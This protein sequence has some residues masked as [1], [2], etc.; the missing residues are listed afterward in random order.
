MPFADDLFNKRVVGNCRWINRFARMK[1][2]P[3]TEV[4]LLNS[5]NGELEVFRTKRLLVKFSA[6]RT[7][8]MSR[9][10]TTI[11]MA[12]VLFSVWRL[13]L[14]RAVLHPEFVDEHSFDM[15]PY[16]FCFLPVRHCN[17]DVSV[18]G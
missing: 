7:A 11:G 16:G 18:D 15:I 8:Y 9:G 4:C 6:L 5:I 17:N 14:K 3:I 1:Y 12:R 10:S 2:L 13:H